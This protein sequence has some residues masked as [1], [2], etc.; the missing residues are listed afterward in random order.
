MNWALAYLRPVCGSTLDLYHQDAFRC[1]SCLGRAEPEDGRPKA[2]GPPAP[3]G[4]P[5]EWG[6][7]RRPD[8]CRPRGGGGGEPGRIWAGR[9]EAEA[10]RELLAIG[11]TVILLTLSLHRY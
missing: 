8:G 3:A 7:P 5:A 9:E 4:C 2:Q 10:E 6:R 1:S 11:E